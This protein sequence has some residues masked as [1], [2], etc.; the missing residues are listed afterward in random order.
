[1]KLNDLPVPASLQS[2]LLGGSAVLAPA[3]K[4]VLCGLVGAPPKDPF[5]A[6][7][8][9]GWIER[10][11]L[12]WADPRAAGAYRG[13]PVDIEGPGDV[14]HRNSILIG[15]AGSDSPIVLDFRTEPPCVLFLP[16]DGPAY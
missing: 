14:D 6:L 8:G 5:V 16:D 11:N 12:A 2:A 15:F 7:C 1:V 10:E 4:A 3:E 9:A 13:S